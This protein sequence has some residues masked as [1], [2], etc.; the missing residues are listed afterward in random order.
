MSK[1]PS[2]LPNLPQFDIRKKSRFK[3]LANL[4]SGIKQPGTEK[5]VSVVAPLSPKIPKF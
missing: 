5:P 4:L 1:D 2:K 3:K